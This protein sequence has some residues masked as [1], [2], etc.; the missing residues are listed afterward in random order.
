LLLA[1]SLF[2]GLLFA[3]QSHGDAGSIDF[4]RQIRPILSNHCFKCHGPDEATREAGLRLDTAEGAQEDFGGYQ[5]ITPGDPAASAVIERIRSADPGLRMPPPD[6][7]LD[8]SNAQIELLERWVA[9]GGTYGQHWAFRPIV[10]PAIPPATAEAGPPAEAP[11]TEARAG[12]GQATNGPLDRFID[13]RLTQHGLHRSPPAARPILIRRLYLDLLGIL[14]APGVVEAFETDD[15]PAAY[16]RLVD[17]LLANPHL[18]EKWGRHWLDQA[19]YA[20]THGYTVDSPRTMWPFRDWVIDAL[21]RDMPFDQFTVDQLAGDLRPDPTLAQQVATGFHR[22][23][24]INQEGGTD[25]EQFRNEATVD[26]VNTTG[27]VWLGLTVGCAQCHTHKYDPLTHREYYQLFAFFNQASDTNS[28]APTVEVVSASQARRVDQLD[29]Q[30]ARAQAALDGFDRGREEK[31][32]QRGESSMRRDQPVEWSVVTIEQHNSAAGAAFKPLGDGSLLVGG[33]NGDEDVYEFTFRSPLKEISGLRLETLTHPS[34]PNGGPGRAGNGNFVL[35]RIDLA[36]GGKEAD[37]LHASADHSQKDYDIRYA[38]DADA[39]TGWAINGAKRLNVQRTA[40]F[41]FPRMQVE[42]QEEGEG[43]R[44]KVT[45]RFG[46]QPPKYNIGRLRLAVTAAAAGQL[47]VPDPER[48]PF[49]K[50][51]QQAKA[52]R[53]KAVQS[54][55]KTMVMQDRQT[56]RANHVLIRGDFLRKGDPVEAETPAF[57]PDLQAQAGRVDRMDLARWLVRPDH[58][59]TARVTVNRLWMRL[60]GRGLVETENDFGLQGTPPTHPELLDWLSREL[61]EN[62]WSIK[63]LL[64]TIVLSETYRQASEWSETRRAEDP[65]NKWLSRQSRVRVDAEIVRDLAQS[66]SGLLDREIGGPSVYPPQPDGV[67]AFTQRRAAWPTSRGAAR[68]R[69][70]LYTF[71]MRSAPH[72]MLTTFDVPAFNTTCTRRMRSN[73]PLQSLTMANDTAM[74]EAARG[75]AERVLRSDPPADVNR[76]AEPPIDRDRQRIARTFQYCFARQ[77][78]SA[79]SD[80]LLEFLRQQRARFAAHPQQAVAW[81]GAAAGQAASAAEI[82]DVAATAMLARVLINLDEF[83][84]RE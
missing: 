82:A 39:A 27:A 23:T 79:E 60:F 50:A 57:L 70:G 28:V 74:V 3:R 7:G 1:A 40:Q 43:T 46:E 10:R 75:L 81:A 31:A 69:R 35:N 24:L 36:V 42:P 4:A 55:P 32:S 51:L 20:D 77:P 59:L 38:I 68:H 15:Q 25:A 6:S 11:V 83:I 44:I 9:E 78:S 71:F 21:N 64:R 34:L 80:R 22:N 33:T 58:P 5:P 47:G 72:P 16:Q 65:L 52:A 73:T 8:L 67:Y 41:V 61:I 26:R 12:M 29:Q 76:E 13:R 37:W 66:A 48:A 49:A 18:G 2:G 56:P 63:H 17:R 54:F 30:V 62:D 45:M 53:A 19:R 14:P 84:T